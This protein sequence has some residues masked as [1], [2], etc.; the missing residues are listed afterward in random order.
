MN[1]IIP[2][3]SSGLGNRLFQYAAAQ[4]LS[5]QTGR[6]LRFCKKFCGESP[7]GDTMTLFRMFPGTAHILTVSSE[8]IICKEP[9]R[10]FYEFQ[11]LGSEFP[12]YKDIIVDGFRQS[13][14]YFPKNIWL[15]EP[16]WEVAIGKFTLDIIGNSAALNT[17]ELRKNTVSVHVRLGD[18]KNLPHHQQELA[19]YY[20]QALSHIKPG[21]R[22]HL[23][24]DEPE[25]CSDI[26]AAYARQQDLVFTVAKK[27][28][29][30]E[31]LY[32]M[33]LCRGGNIVANSTFSWWGAW[34]AHQHGSPWATYPSK[35][36]QGMPEPTDLFPSWATI[37]EV[38]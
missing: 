37:I 15:L 10:S 11:E 12:P 3:L 6:P 17:E 35:W 22:I 21:S 27:R 18:Y 7:H 28:S 2:N 16:I 30:V 23:F 19:H 24:S 32:E 34:Y 26:F 13:P 4:A 31:S 5:E 20:K 29:D 38:A 25:L 9:T 14:K 1:Y 36:G 33:S 8:I